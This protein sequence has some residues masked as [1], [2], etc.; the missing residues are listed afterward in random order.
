MKNILTLSIVIP[1]Y[2]EQSYLKACL[3]SIVAQ[4]QKPDEVIVV[5]N[6]STDQTAKLAKS[7][8]FVRLLREPKRGVVFARNRGFNAASST[9][10]GRIDADTILAADWVEK[11]KAAY[12]KAGQPEL[13]AASAGS[14]F[15]NQGW[16]PAWRALHLLTYFWPSRLILGH[17]TLVGSNMFITRK[18][19]LSVRAATCKRTDVHEDMDL[20]WHAHRAG[21]KVN[22]LRDLKASILARQMP[23]R[24]LSYPRM[25]IR[26]RLIN[27]GLTVTTKQ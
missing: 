7:Y 12:V 9:L 25:M 2:N 18:L 24:L 4:T 19:W 1:V 14:T 6:N 22:L 17:S 11:V 8:K 23:S 10:I 3:D 5:D 15:R 21:A 16:A 13:Y 20:A 27:H 26:V